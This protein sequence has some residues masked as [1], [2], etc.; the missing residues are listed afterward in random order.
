M[1]DSLMATMKE[2]LLVLG[3]AV[4]LLPLVVRG[5]AMGADW[6]ENFV[7]HNANLKRIFHRLG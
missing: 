6:L 7:E 5:L 3:A 4:A 1:L 2:P